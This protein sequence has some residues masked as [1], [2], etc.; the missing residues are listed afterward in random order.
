MVKNKKYLKS[1]SLFT[2]QKNNEGMLRSLRRSGGREKWPLKNE[3]K[4]KRNWPR[5]ERNKLRYL[6]RW[7]LK[8]N[9]KDRKEEKRKREGDIYTETQI[10]LT[11]IICQ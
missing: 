11:I 10:E 3:P 9:K 5:P 4:S 1:Q 6:L 8:S 2:Q 7:L